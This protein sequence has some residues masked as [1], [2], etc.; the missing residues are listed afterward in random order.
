MKG[1]G[2]F[3]SRYALFFRPL[4]QLDTVLINEAHLPFYVVVNR[5]TFDCKYSNDASGSDSWPR[6]W[7]VLIPGCGGS[8]S[9]LEVWD[10]AASD[11]SASV[12]FDSD[13]A[14]PRQKPQLT[15]Q[16]KRLCC[17]ILKVVFGPCL[18]AE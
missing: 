6:R 16:R 13:L 1:K 17:I 18:S 14:N 4:F 3:T 8:D 2:F 11:P 9:V 15:T 5:H 12:G 7:F 10:Q